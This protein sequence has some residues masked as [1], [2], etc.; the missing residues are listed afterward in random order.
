MT[1]TFAEA[2]ALAKASPADKAGFADFCRKLLALLV[3]VRKLYR[4]RACALADYLDA[5]TAETQ[6]GGDERDLVDPLVFELLDALGYRAAD[7]LYNVHLTVASGTA[8]PDFILRLGDQSGSPPML[9]VES[10]STHIVDFARKLHRTG[11]AESPV[12]QLRRYVH[13]GV[14]QG[15]LGLLCNGWRLEAWLFD[16]EG[17]APIISVDLHALGR[18]AL[19][20]P[21]SEFPPPALRSALAALWRRCSRDAYAD[22]EQLIRR[23]SRVPPPPPHWIAQLRSSLDDGELDGIRATIHRYHEELWQGRAIDVRTVPDRLVDA[24]R[25]LI[26]RFAEDVQHQLVGQLE[27]HRA[28]SRAVEE[29]E[30]EAGMARRREELGLSQ[31]AF[32]LTADEYHR[33]YLAPLDAWCLQPTGPDIG[34][35]V[36]EWLARLRP[37]VRV[38]HDDAA[39]QLSL[40]DGPASAPRARSYSDEQRQQIIG[41]MRKLTIELC[42]AAFERQVRVNEMTVEYASSEQCARAFD[43]WAQRVSSSVMVGASDEVLHR[44]FA[45]QTAYVYLVRLLVVRICED[46]GLFLRKLSN[47]GLIEWQATA[48]R[49]LDY[50]S[51]RS[52]EYLTRMAYDCAR[53]V[54]HH[55]FGAF[56]IFDWYRMDE[57]M[58]LRAIL[59]LDAF[60]LAHVDTD[61][62]G[63]VYGRFLEEGKHE[64]GRYYTPRPL[65][66]AMLDQIG[67]REG[68]IIGRRLIDLACG[69]GSFLVEACRRLIDR[70]R[71]A[72][73]CIPD[74]NLAAVIAEVQSSIHGLDINPFA[75][76]L[77]ETNLLIQVL[78]LVRQAMLAGRRLSI[79]RFQILCDDALAFDES[80]YDPVIGA[81]PLVVRTDQDVA[82]LIKARRGPYQAGFDFVIGNPPYVRADE[83]SAD[84]QAYRR[85]LEGQ[86]WFTTRHLKWDLYVPF[87][88]QYLRLCAPGTMPRGCLITIESIA[89]AP[90]AAKLRT[91]LAERATIHEIVFIDGMGL[92]EDARWQNNIVFSFSPLAPPPGH[93]VRR[94]TASRIGPDGL[95]L[96]VP[97]D[98]TG[99]ATLGPDRLFNKRPQVALSLEGTVPLERVFYVT[100]GMTQNASEKM[101]D[102]APVAVPPEYD[103]EAFGEELIEDRGAAGKVIAHRRFGR[104]DLVADAPDAIHTRPTIGS[105]EV[106]RGGIGRVRWL[107]FGSHTRCPARV[108]APTFPELYDRTKLM[109]GTFTGVAVDEGEPPGYVTV[110][111][112]I[113]LAVRWDRLNGIHNR[114]IN[115]ARRDLAGRG[116]PI[117]T[118][119]SISEWYVCALALSAPIQDWLAANRRSMKDHVYPNDIKSIPL[120]LI[121][122][123]EQAPF[124]ELA[125]ERHRLYAA[126]IERERDGFALGPPPAAPIR[127]LTLRFLAEHPELER[128]TLFRAQGRGVFKVEPSFIAADLARARAR[129]DEIRV[130]ASLVA[131]LGPSLTTDRDAI[132]TWLAAYLAALPSTLVDRQQIDEIPATPDGLRALVKAIEAALAE[133]VGWQARIEEINARLDA[134]AWNLYRPAAPA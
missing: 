12:D 45:R 93:R 134:L 119:N 132:A 32:T 25:G 50:A 109:F 111:D 69:S 30:A 13:S 123:A 91:L 125:R 57:K 63:T 61:I 104:D 43:T 59:V 73:G 133:I 15:R 38:R 8:T 31:S 112:S 17:D 124:I 14:I 9:I 37:H 56:A 128:L 66:D 49:Y 46:K 101:A 20:Q 86:S 64:Q 82:Q 83:P 99:Q 6:P 51:G 21:A 90:Y 85:R 33:L 29:I 75:C 52:Y 16:V 98:E 65:V 106:L 19:D 95:P 108:R 113:R 55:F 96:R 97:L 68:D 126:L 102:G 78:D 72:D 84:Y 89:T 58:L 71:G 4:G 10:K 79:D 115:R 22:A 34:G 39:E 80:Q 114:A 26:D 42:R 24:L 11:R 110:S 2:L 35:L 70:Y 87:V 1:E 105:R 131:Q 67:Y 107:E 54:Y 48:E 3:K 60:N 47:G 74:D 44:E 92:F 36:D 120:K 28:F 130:G 88:E 81:L 118:P 40:V 62:I 5:R 27:R 18:A 23:A 94:F 116:G 117:A 100:V 76:Y 121:P 127:A 122:P 103:P 77:A 7:I 41:D 53:N 129:G